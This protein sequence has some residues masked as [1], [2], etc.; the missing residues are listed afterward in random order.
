MQHLWVWLQAKPAGQQ[1]S[2]GHTGSQLI[3][4]QG[5]REHVHE[6]CLQAFCCIRSLVQ[7]NYTL[8]VHRHHGFLPVHTMTPLPCLVQ[9]A[10]HYKTMAL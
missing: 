8:A 3:T 9:T 1:A 5:R 4:A 2:T 6:H 10:W 7:T